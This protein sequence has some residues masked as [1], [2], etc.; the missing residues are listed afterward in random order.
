MHFLGLACVASLAATVLAAPT[1]IHSNHVLHE[2]RDASLQWVKRDRL[3]RDVKLP[4][5]IGLTQRNLDEGHEALMQVSHPDSP[6]YGK[7]KTAEEVIEMF[8]PAAST[9]DA[10]R[11]WLENAGIEASRISQSVNKQWLQF[12]AKSSE[13]EELLNAK[14]HFFEH[15]EHGKTTIA[16]DEYA[17]LLSY[18]LRSRTDQCQILRPSS[19]ARAHRL[20]YSGHQAVRQ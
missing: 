9:V 6:H 13:A 1:S 3:H 18:S 14:Y 20:Y 17:E 15:S 7:H 11:A 5:R 4:M 16:C 8:A 19:R 2:R 12:D 10:V